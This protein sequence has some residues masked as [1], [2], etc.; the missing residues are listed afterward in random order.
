MAKSLKLYYD[1]MSQPS[2]VLW[3]LLEKSKIPYERCLVN[4]GKGEHLTDQF[5]EINR[6]QKV[7]CI[8]DSQIK[9]AESVAI[10]RY[11]A[12]EYQLPEH[13]YPTDS[14]RQA[15]VDEYLEWQHHNTRASCATYFQYVWL[16]PRMMGSTVDPKRA[17]QY[18]SQLDS[19]LDF[20]EQVF[21]GHGSPYI[22][23]DQISIADLVAAC[24]IEQPKM[25]GYDPCAGRPNLTQ[26]MERVRNATNPYYDQAHKLVYKIMPDSVP[27]PKL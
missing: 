21:L 1:L 16:R 10:A 2:R 15:R 11:L 8:V 7:P 14:R 4:L 20:I 13:W 12:R 3:I 19:C 9:L 25:A 17:E 5:K 24:E 18:K 22:V 27:K 26:W 6:F 23:G